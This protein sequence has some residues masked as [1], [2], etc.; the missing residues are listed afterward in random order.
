MMRFK[1]TTS[2]SG[3]ITVARSNEMP[4]FADV[5]NDCVGTRS[6]RGAPPGLST[7]WIEEALKEFRPPLGVS[8]ASAIFSGN[9]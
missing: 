9:A 3:D 1:F 8:K 7:Y 4:L 6:P 5:L 2:S